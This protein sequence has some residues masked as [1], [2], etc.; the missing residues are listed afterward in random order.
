MTNPSNFNPIDPKPSYKEGDIVKFDTNQDGN[1]KEGTICG[2]STNNVIDFWI[3]K[4][5]DAQNQFKGYPYSCIVVPH[6][7]ILI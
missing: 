3:I 5:S 1:I 6:V 2:I 4:L 7:L